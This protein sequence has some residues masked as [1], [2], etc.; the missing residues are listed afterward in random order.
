MVGGA[1]LLVA[2]AD[3]TGAPVAADPD[4]P[5][6]LAGRFTAADEAFYLRRYET[7]VAAVRA[8]QATTTYDTLATV[9]GARGDVPLRRAGRGAID[10]SAIETAVAYARG[11]KSS[12][13]MI[14]K[15]G[16]VV[17]EAYFG[18]TTPDTLINSK[19]LAKPLGVVA[20]GRAIERGAIVGLD[21]PVADFITEWRDTPKNRI[22]VRHLLDM[23][24][25]LLAQARA[26]GPDH[27]LNRAYLHPRH[28]EVI[29]H[30]YPLTHPP[31]SRYDYSN[32]TSELVAPLIERA[33]GQRYEDWVADQVLAPIGARGGTIWLNREGGVAHAGCCIQLPAES[34]LRLAL[35]VMNDGVWDGQR[36]LPPDFALAMRTPTPQNPFVGMGL[37]VGAT[38]TPWRGAA[39]PDTDFPVT[40]HSEPYVDADLILFDGNGNQVAYMVPSKNLVIL[41]LGDRPPKQP[42]WDNAFLPNLISRA[43]ADR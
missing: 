33:T 19:S 8:G 39:N 25:G 27:I 26:S 29:I 20:V 24:S 36:L 11:N 1:A 7:F 42:P 34:W 2:Q 31:G 4:A 13:L 5:D 37:Y 18:Q 17:H 41:R 14:A 6:A 38:Y 9:G 40:Y 12:V 43:L 22:L 35:L 15:D 16:A 28:D 30:D 10:A 3:P 32:A 23:R 21:Q